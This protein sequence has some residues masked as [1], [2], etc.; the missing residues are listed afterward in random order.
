MSCASQGAFS[1]KMKVN[2][3][4]GGTRNTQFWENDAPRRFGYLPMLQATENLIKYVLTENM[5]I[6][7]AILAN[8]VKDNIESTKT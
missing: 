1:W 3:A 2:C 7:G 5:G 8:C 4:S 6:H